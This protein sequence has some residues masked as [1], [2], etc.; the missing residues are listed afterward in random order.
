MAVGPME[1]VVVAVL[2]LLAAAAAVSVA[3]TVL[4]TI[5]VV[6]APAMARGTRRL[7]RWM[8]RDWHPPTDWLPEPSVPEGPHPLRP[9]LVRGVAY[10]PTEEP[11][12]VVGLVA[13]QVAFTA[14]RPGPMFETVTMVHARLARTATLDL[15]AHP[16][17]HTVVYVL[18]GHGRVGRRRH[19]SAGQLA[20]VPSGAASVAACADDG[21]TGL[22]LLVL[23]EVRAPATPV[24]GRKAPA[25]ALPADCHHGAPGRR[26]GAGRGGHR[27]AAV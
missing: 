2:G 6:M 21:A 25:R 20:I 27:P 4:A 13:A 10:L 26:A 3:V 18:S 15:A 23:G 24:R 7:Q 11:G 22:E 1:I 12:A 17:Y 16:G 19:V 8:W 14:R 5:A 9:P